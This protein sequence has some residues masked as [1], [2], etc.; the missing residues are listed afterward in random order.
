[1]GGQYTAHPHNRP[2]GI[3]ASLSREATKAG[4]LQRTCLAKIR[5]KE[6]QGTLP[7]NATFIFYELEQGGA[8]PKAYLVL[9]KIRRRFPWLELIWADGGYNACQFVAA[10]AKVPL[11]RLEIVKR[12]DDTKG[13]VV[14]PRRWVVERTFSWFVQPA[15]RQGL[16]ETCQNPGC[17]RCP[18][19]HSACSQAACQGADRQLAN[20]RFASHDGEGLQTRCEGT[21]AGTRGNG[22][23]APIPD[24][25]SLRPDRTGQIDPLE[26]IP[27]AGSS[28]AL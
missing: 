19:L 20:P 6:D 23:V 9:N 26:P 17:L 25:R 2:K 15:S 12:D 11:L 22:E 10:V 18:R 7:T 8:I 13:F 16:R 1:M 28:S 4:R 24:G 3:H 5:E 27:A 21:I 14:L